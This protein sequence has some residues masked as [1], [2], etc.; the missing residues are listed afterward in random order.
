[1][2]T[3]PPPGRPLNP[4]ASRRFVPPI[5][6]LIAFECAARVGSFTRAAEELNL[7]QG[8]VSRQIL[9]LEEQI[10]VRL[11]DRVKQRVVLTPIG[12][13]Y[14]DQIRDALNRFAAATAQAIAYRGGGGT[15]DLAILPTFGA[16]WLVPRIPRFFA[17]HRDV[18]VNF[19][20]RVRPVDLRREGLDAA[21]VRGVPT[22][23]GLDIHK[24]MGEEL[25]AVAAPSLVAAMRA[26]DPDRL[27]GV[28]LLVQETRPGAWKDWF[29]AQGL[30]PPIESGAV[31]FE[32]FLLVIRAAV[33]GLGA[34]VVPKFL[35]EDELKADELRI[36]PGS[37]VFNA[38]GY[39]LVYPVEYRDRPPLQTFR[40]W[41]LDVATEQT[42]SADTMV[43]P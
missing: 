32:Q 36:T 31:V 42:A 1:M 7:T 25:V 4:L 2:K 5:S 39:Y 30:P 20:T 23:S 14:A 33:A 41:L 43:V 40:R 11:F 15:L 37:S 22:Q 6:S 3:K 10:G 28:T 21:I 9:Q 26:D 12:R 19:S 27:A 13:T 16:R 17:A 24:L 29:A 8:A 35:V 34:A 38:D 18:V